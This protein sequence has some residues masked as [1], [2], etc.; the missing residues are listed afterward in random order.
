MSTKK[1]SPLRQLAD[2]ISASVDKI[3]AI[4]EEKGLEYP[5]L[6]TPI[7]PTS[8]SEVAARDPG[9]LQAAAFA[10]AACSQLGAMLHAPAIAL[11]Q[12]ALS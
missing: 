11:N 12:L 3:D 6:F 9:V 5:D 7:D 2:L 10:I 8:A 4:F 1:P